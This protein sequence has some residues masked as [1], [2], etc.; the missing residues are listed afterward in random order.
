MPEEVLPD[1]YQIPLPLPK[2]PLRAINTYLIRG[3]G[4]WLLVD[5]GM[6]RPECREAMR[7]ALDTLSVDLGRT[8]L[9]VTHGHSDHVGQV[10]ELASSTSKIFLGPEDAAIVLD[11]DLW[12]KLAEAARRYGFP[13]ATAAVERHPG[14]RY[15]FS[16]RPEFTPVQDGDAMPI[17][18]YAFRCVATPGHTPGHVC[19]YDAGARLLISGDHI[20]DTITPNISGWED[21]T[22]A[23]GDFLASLDKIAA[24]DIGLVLPSHRNLF[25]DP[26][27]RIEELK[28][29]H[30]HRLDEALQIL[31][32]GP[33][34]AY[35]VASLMKWDLDC[36]NWES[37][38]TPQKWFATGEA[39]AHL[40]HLERT[41]KIQKVWREERYCFE[42]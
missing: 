14:K 19:L 22:D 27:R 3:E 36:T 7:S 35:E 5:T 18:R 39:L 30:R 20:L 6:N 34:T 15:L 33:Q 16:G 41:G 13:D 4:R 11:Q 31:A 24:Y 32:A 23:L 12:T 9:F 25:S 10:T 17:G 8:D 37:F 2:N 1:I 42:T 29:H 40:R 26:L 21:E 38:P 28:V